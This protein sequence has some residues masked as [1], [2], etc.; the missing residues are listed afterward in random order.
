LSYTTIGELAA[1]TA[2]EISETLQDNS[3]VRDAFQKAKGAVEFYAD[4]TF[5]HI[6]TLEGTRPPGECVGAADSSR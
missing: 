3:E 6:R 5:I 2:D 4:G 1:Q